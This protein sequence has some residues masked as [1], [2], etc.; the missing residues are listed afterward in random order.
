MHL[1]D[2]H[3]PINHRAD[4]KT[5]EKTCTWVTD[6]GPSTTGR[7][8]E[9][10]TRGQDGGTKRREPTSTAPWSRADSQAAGQANRPRRDDV[11]AIE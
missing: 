11:A 3:R 2:G 9:G 5:K 1:G 8:R 7:D 10:E 4:T 6:I